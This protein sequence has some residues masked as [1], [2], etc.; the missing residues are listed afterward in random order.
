MAHRM[1]KGNRRRVNT[2]GHYDNAQQLDR[3]THISGTGTKL[4]QALISAG[5]TQADSE[6][7]IEFCTSKCPYEDCVI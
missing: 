2:I 4:C 7:A 5:I 6:E 1:Y 3:R